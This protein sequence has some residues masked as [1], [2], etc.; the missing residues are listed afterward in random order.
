M[1]YRTARLR[2]VPYRAVLPSLLLLWC[3]TFGL[4]PVLA[5]ADNAARTGS[6]CGCCSPVSGTSEHPSS[7]LCNALVPTAVKDF[8]LPPDF[9]TNLAGISPVLLVEWKEVGSILRAASPPP[10]GPPPYL[11]QLRLLI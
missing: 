10:S 4:M 8:T 7:D 1:T 2:G 9:C 5:A 6:N 11:K 3:T